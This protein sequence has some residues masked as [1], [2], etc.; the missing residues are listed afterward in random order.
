VE[1]LIPDSVLKLAQGVIDGARV[2]IAAFSVKG[3]VDI[4]D[5]AAIVIAEDDP[6]LARLVLCGRA[7]I[8]RLIDSDLT[9]EI[10][11]TLSTSAA[12]GCFWMV[13]QQGR[14]VVMLQA[15]MVD[16]DDVTADAH[17]S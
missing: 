4:E 17:Q 12:P 3:A 5:V 11:D 14:H 1:P 7:E 13:L 6:T 15:T 2:R 10:E 8:A 16:G 9:A